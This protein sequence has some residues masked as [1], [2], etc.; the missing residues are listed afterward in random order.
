[1]SLKGRNPFFQDI[2]SPG[3]ICH[4]NLDRITEKTLQSSEART[5]PASYP[6]YTDF[7]SQPCQHWCLFS[8]IHQGLLPSVRRGGLQRSALDREPTTGKGH[9][10][11]HFQV[12]SLIL[13]P[14]QGPPYCLSVWCPKINTDPLVLFISFGWNWLK[15]SEKF[16]YSILKNKGELKRPLNTQTRKDFLTLSKPASL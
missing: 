9:L 3:W 15:L 2:K 12:S 16:L 4:Y 8:I 14:L 5:N 1:M 7:Q 6:K 13:P 11:K 10:K